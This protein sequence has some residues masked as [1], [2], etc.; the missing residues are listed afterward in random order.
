MKQS[1]KLTSILFLTLLL[2][3]GE[4]KNSKSEKFFP[5]LSYIQSQV[6]HVDTSLYSI[7]KIIFI[8]D[9][10]TDTIHIPRE[11]FRNEARDFLNIPDLMESKFQKRFTET[12]D[13]D[14]TINRV[15]LTYLP[16][17][18]DKEEI[19]RQEVL[20]APDPSGDRIT[21]IFIDKMVVTK[22]S[23]VQKKMI[24][25]TDKSFQVT[26]IKQV[27]EQPET[28]STFKVL[29]NEGDE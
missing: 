12:K 3:C 1:L 13:F 7:R 21:S 22:D 2:S 27:K 10:L 5:V 6:A 11:A 9:T 20:I 4:K 16:V 28:T 15:M 26:T 8:S 18:P 24:W 19:L 17:N 25:L 29:W 14:E 23:S